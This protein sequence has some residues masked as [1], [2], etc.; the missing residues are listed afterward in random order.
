MN[1]VS[2]EGKEGIKATIIADS[3]DPKGKR[4][5]TFEL[6]YPRMIHA[7]LMTHRLFS[8]NAASSR[9]I[10]ILKKMGMVWNN[11]AMPV[12]WGKNQPGMQAVAELTS[13]KLKIGKAG[14][15]LA[16]K[17]A[18]GSA[19][20]LYKAGVH[21]QITNRILEPFERYKV[22]VTATEYDNWFWLRDHPDAQ[23]EI[24]ELAGLMAAALDESSPIF[25]RLGDW[26][27][28]YITTEVRLDGTIEYS[29]K[30][31]PEPGVLRV[32]KLSLENAIKVSASCCAQVS[33]RTVNKSVM[34]ALAIY[35]KLVTSTPVHASPFEHQATPMMV[36]GIDPRSGETQEGV[37]HYDT[38][39]NTWSGNLMG[40]IQYRQTI[41][42]NAH[43]G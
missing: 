15:K 10:P 17:I 21:K 38:K 11:P 13:V 12:H 37:T 26:H 14:W 1:E 40:W 33:F 36:G 7:E 16:S 22:V 20:V 30:I 31:E 6:E 25:L 24:Q 32:V 39:G 4:I 9:A 2:I 19:Y 28:P 29:V 8:R 18:C 3:V 42:N 35:E 27:L 5:T 23:P 41:P 34:I 43:W